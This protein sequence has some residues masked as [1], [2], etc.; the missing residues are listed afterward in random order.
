MTLEEMRKPYTRPEGLPWGSKEGLI[1]AAN[2]DFKPDQDKLEPVVK[3]IKCIFPEMWCGSTGEELRQS[4]LLIESAFTYGFIEGKRA[5]R[6]R[7]KK[8]TD[9]MTI[10]QQIEWLL[11]HIEDDRQSR[12]IL[13]AVARIYSGGRA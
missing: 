7:H 11:D 4:M 13:A 6:A 9:G 12:A 3:M 2:A 10:R 8:N 5:E 1:I